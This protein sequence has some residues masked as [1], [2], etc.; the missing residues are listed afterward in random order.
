MDDDVK[1]LSP[2]SLSN[3]IWAA[4]HRR[5]EI[6]HKHDAQERR[7]SRGYHGQNHV[8]RRI[9]ALVFQILFRSPCETKTNAF[10]TMA[11]TK[12][13]TTCSISSDYT[14]SNSTRSNTISTPRK[15]N[16]Q[17]PPPPRSKLY[18]PYILPHPTAPP[19]TFH[20][21]SCSSLAPTRPLLPSLHPI[22]PLGPPHVAPLSPPHVISP[23][24]HHQA[25]RLPHQATHHATAHQDSNPCSCRP[26]PTG[27]AC[28]GAGTPP[29]CCP[30]PQCAERA[31]YKEAD[32]MCVNE[33]EVAC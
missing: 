4:R 9:D 18:C 11:P 31:A 26:L 29:T 15:R 28:S 32:V 23:H 10:T 19:P 7:T 27:A 30:T 3:A 8:K 20:T 5:T 2:A 25:M 22:S 14:A 16:K 13:A 1:P 24:L 21:Y 12:L 17:V 6:P 33:Q